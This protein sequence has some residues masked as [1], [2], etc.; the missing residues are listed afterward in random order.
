MIPTV[1][2]SSTFKQR[3]QKIREDKTWSTV[4]QASTIQNVP[5]LQMGAKKLGYAA[6]IEIAT[7]PFCGQAL[8]CL[9]VRPLGRA[10]QM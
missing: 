1:Q 8:I 2:S 4:R 5:F 10:Q 6:F 3:G 7:H 9:T